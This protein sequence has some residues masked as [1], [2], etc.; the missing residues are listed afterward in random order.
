MTPAEHATS[1]ISGA[2]LCKRGAAIGRSGNHCGFCIA[3]AIRRAQREAIEEAI[4]VAE[5]QPIDIDWKPTESSATWLRDE[6]VRK[7]KGLVSK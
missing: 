7:L 6:I 5:Q 2:D 1:L 3:E 4:K